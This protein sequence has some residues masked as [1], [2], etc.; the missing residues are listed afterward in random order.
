MRLKVKEAR[1]I[2]TG[3]AP[4]ECFVIIM[5]D[6]IGLWVTNRNNHD[7]GVQAGQ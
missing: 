4:Y 1:P 2:L 3:P 6:V 5:Y 7:D